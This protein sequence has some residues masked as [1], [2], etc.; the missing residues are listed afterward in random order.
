MLLAVAWAVLLLLA[1]PAAAHSTVMATSP[2]DDQVTPTAPAAVSVTFNEPVELIPAGSLQVFSPSGTRVDDGAVQQ[3]NGN[4]ETVTVGLTRGLPHGTYTASWRVISADSHPVAGAFTFAIGA[5]SA[6]AVGVGTVSARGSTLV[7][8]V[9]AAARTV[10]YA[11]F[12]VLAGVT[13]F[14]T[15]CWPAGARTP[16]ARRLLGGSWAVLVA[17]TLAIWALQGP[18]GTAAGLGSALDPALLRATAHTRLGTAL[19]VRL[20]LLAAAAPALLWIA[21]RLPGATGRTRSAAGTATTVL[22]A[23]TA[24]TWAVADHAGTG[25][26]VLLAMPA[27]ILHLT[28][29]AFWLGGLVLLACVVLRPGS[30][31]AEPELATA[32]PRFS[33]IALGC[34]AVLA[35]SGLYQALRQV[36][37]LSALTGTQYGRL[38]LF[39]TLGMAALIALGYRARTWTTVHVGR[40]RRSSPP[41]GPQPRL[42]TA[43]IRRSVALETAIAVGVL[44][45]S[46][47]LVN[48]A[49]A[50]EAHPSPAAATASFDTGGTHGTGTV[51]AA[52]TRAGTDGT[53]LRLA[54]LDPAG[55]PR[56]VP[57]VRAALTLP[58]RSIG[59]LPITLTATGP[60]TYSGTVPT[61]IAGSW[62]LSV[63]VRTDDVDETTVVLQVPI[64]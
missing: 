54:V 7:G 23:A 61:L 14:L 22:T 39:K 2:G 16:G 38:L 26:Q 60:G 50:R 29:M 40:G 42:P 56:T 41:P 32:L 51:K 30:A 24:A 37:S 47:V 57:E 53:S 34:V 5:P 31:A 58:T 48:T 4:V 27:D 21:T 63:T 18:Y 44:A 8:T 20:G 55:R 36:D 10:A 11:A 15:L 3:P 52:V 28:A 9:Y 12:A 64:R 49:P 43:R 62:Q 6:T 45:L 17:A 59:P 33:A 19:S 13:A 46:A 35:A 25:P 1:G